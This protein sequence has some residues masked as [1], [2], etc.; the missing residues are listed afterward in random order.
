MESKNIS[1]SSFKCNN[2]RDEA[3]K[4]Y[5][6]QKFNK[7]EINPKKAS[8]FKTINN[9]KE[10]LIFSKKKNLNEL[11]QIKPKLVKMGLP[12]VFNIIEKRHSSYDKEKLIRSKHLVTQIFM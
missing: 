10:I 6:S 7:K 5:S 9:S 3:L 11:N 2:F 4:S 1:E 12:S 8:Q